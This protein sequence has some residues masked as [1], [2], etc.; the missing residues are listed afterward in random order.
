MAFSNQRSPILYVDV[1]L[2]FATERVLIY[3]GETVE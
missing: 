2:G 3:E 1:N